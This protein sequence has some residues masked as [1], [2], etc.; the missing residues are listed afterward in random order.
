MLPKEN[1]NIISLVKSLLFCFYLDAVVTEGACPLVPAAK[2]TKVFTTMQSQKVP[3]T[4]HK[5]PAAGGKASWA[6]RRLDSHK[7]PAARNTS[8][9]S[10]RK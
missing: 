2:L 10:W 7:S 8:C 9:Q 1:V 3:L 6:W 5:P 4:E